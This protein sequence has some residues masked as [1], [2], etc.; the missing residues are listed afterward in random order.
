MSNKT[1]KSSTVIDGI[2]YKQISL[3]NKAD[4]WWK[5]I[6]Q[7]PEGVEAQ[8]LHIID[9]NRQNSHVEKYVG[10][11]ELKNEKE[12]MK[13]PPRF[14][15]MKVGLKGQGIFPSPSGNH[16][17][18]LRGA[19]KSEEWISEEYYKKNKEKYEIELGTISNPSVL[20]LKG[21]S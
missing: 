7:V 8:G 14:W 19:D 5:F 3:K 9:K 15:A 13:N 1:K 20:K 12:Y 2:E 6:P 16:I 17:L 21:L 4:Q 11:K 10:K 18:V